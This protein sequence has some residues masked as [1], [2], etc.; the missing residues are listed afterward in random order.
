MWKACRQFE[1]GYG[2]THEESEAMVVAV[3][4]KSWLLDR[5]VARRFMTEDA[6]ELEAA[7]SLSARLD[8]IDHCYPSQ[9]RGESYPD[10]WIALRGLAAADIDVAHAPTS[11]LGATTP[12]AATS[13]PFWFTTPS[14]PS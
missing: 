9:P 7:L 2:C 4:F 5:G 3:I 13:R 1:S 11:G 8:W 14:R 12:T 10:V 6:S